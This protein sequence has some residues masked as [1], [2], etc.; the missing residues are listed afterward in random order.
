MEKLK[1]LLLIVVISF[2]ISCGNHNSYQKLIDES[3]PWSVRLA[4]SFLLTHPGAVTYD[5]VMT[6][7]KWNYEQGVMLE[8][9]QKVYKKT[10]DK[11]YFNFIKANIDQYVD[12]S[13]NIKTYKY[14]D[15][16]LDNI[17]PG[18]ALLFLFQ[19]T[20]EEK[21]KVAAEKLRAQ[22]QNQPRT[23]AGGFWHK[24]RRPLSRLLQL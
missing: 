21:Y 13:G 23:K 16:N 22:L 24:K 4:D 3:L 20:G 7:K 6:S 11:K 12:S 1:P 17:N 15:F 10:G 14:S 18:R 2:L 9:L 5:S 19:E 8:A